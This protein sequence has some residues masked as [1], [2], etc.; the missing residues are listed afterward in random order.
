MPYYS[1]ED[2][3]AMLKDQAA[4]LKNQL[5]AVEDRLQSIASGVSRTDES[6]G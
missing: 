4:A 5:R 2:E 6:A 3:A 1:S